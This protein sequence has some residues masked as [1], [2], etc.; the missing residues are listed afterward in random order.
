MENPCKKCEN[1]N[2]DK[3]RPE[4]KDCRKRTTYLA[5]LGGNAYDERPVTVKPAHVAICTAPGCSGKHLAKGLCRSH[6]D[7]Q[8]NRPVKRSQK[9]E[10]TIE[11]AQT[12][13]KKGGKT[14]MKEDSASDPK[15][16]ES[17]LLVIDMSLIPGAE[18]ILKKIDEIGKTEMRPMEYQAAKILQDA[19]TAW[20]G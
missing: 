4:C 13:I 10:K 9:A 6:Y 5:S 14:V 11:T 1:L 17:T 18:E 12:T 2:G 8:Y 16:N 15:T 19:T 20:R 7:R 3:N